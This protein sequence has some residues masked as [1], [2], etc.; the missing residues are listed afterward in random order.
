MT[1]IPPRAL[2]EGVYRGVLF[3]YGGLAAAIGTGIA[4]TSSWDG[5]TVLGACVVVA[6][7][8]VLRR[9][10]KLRPELTGRAGQLQLRGAVLALVSAG[11]IA[12]S[13]GLFFNTTEPGD[14]P[15]AFVPTMILGGLGIGCWVARIAVGI[16]TRRATRTSVPVWRR[17]DASGPAG[18]RLRDRMR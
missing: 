4:I 9:W 6:G 3:F 14:P 5:S 1:F 13:V 16:Q 11:L 7:L 18:R 15:A 8:I 10:W 2:T 12:Q 17:Q